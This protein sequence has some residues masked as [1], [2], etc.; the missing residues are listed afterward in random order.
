M[1]I[2]ANVSVDVDIDVQDIIDDLTNSEKQKVFDY[3]L[4]DLNEELTY[5]YKEHIFKSPESLQDELKYNALKR[6]YDELTLEK[7][8]SFVTQFCKKI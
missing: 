2:Q 4:D 5:G 7:I 8:E 6:L 3:L 1:N